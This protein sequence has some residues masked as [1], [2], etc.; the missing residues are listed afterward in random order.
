MLAKLPGPDVSNYPSQL[1]APAFG[2]MQ[3]GYVKAFAPPRARY[4]LCET[5]ALNITRHVVS[6]VGPHGWVGGGRQR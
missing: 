3:A 5:C 4:R 6:L 1:R 2:D